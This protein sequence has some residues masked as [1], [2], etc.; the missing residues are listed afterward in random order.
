MAGKIFINYRRGDDPGHTG[1]LFDH[2]Q[3]SF[4]SEQLF[5][6]ID[7]IPPGLDF[8]QVI[9]ERVAE[10]DILLA[11]IGK[12][13]IDARDG[14]GVRRLD[15]PDD[16]VRVEIAS[17]LSQGKRVIP[18]LVGDATMPSAD[19]LPDPI[20]PLAR[21]NAVRLTYERF[22]ADT[23]RLIKALQRGLGE[24]E[25]ERRAINPE[26]DR[27]AQ[28]TRRK[29]ERARRDA[30]AA[31]HAEEDAPRE[32]DAK[33]DDVGAAPGRPRRIELR[34]GGRR[35]A[36]IVAASLVLISITAVGTYWLQIVPPPLRAPPS[37][38]ASNPAS[39]AQS[40]L[41]ARSTPGVQS[42]QITEAAPAARSAN[43]APPPA[44][45][46]FG[47]PS[48]LSPDQAAWDLLRETSDEHALKRFMA[49]Y[50]G[51][52][53]Y[54]DAQAR[55]VALEA[56]RAAVVWQ[57]LKNSSDEAS[58]RRFIV[59]YPESIFVA[60]A[61]A[62][63]AALSVASS[64]QSVLPSPDQDAWT[65]LKETTD[66]AASRQLPQLPRSC[67]RRIHSPWCLPSY[68]TRL[69]PALFKI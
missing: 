15:H 28:E 55:I 20:R 34:Q 44:P 56:E 24:I 27:E 7:N 61:Q 45:P 29:G 14:N 36:L 21:R 35:V 13:W 16:F 30:E 12:G 53:L 18:I 62:R 25:A 4:A 60:D 32:H 50:P 40:T 22:R 17:A 67:G 10:C 38:T 51:S 23:L 47:A 33:D 19:Q 59:E 65:I 68:R 54:K 2:L 57:Q 9:N 37:P 1:R 39:A 69:A 3:N 42:A 5:L 48:S 66:A 8:V 43:A 41:E 26:A 46:P 52:T 63:L 49:Q 6:D 58:V 11:V 64:A 31:Y